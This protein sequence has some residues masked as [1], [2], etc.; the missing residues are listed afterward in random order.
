M[1]P[2]AIQ[3]VAS[4]RG[5]EMGSEQLL[6]DGCTESVLRSSEVIKCK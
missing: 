1:P 6:Q 2:A 5:H 4:A 3:R